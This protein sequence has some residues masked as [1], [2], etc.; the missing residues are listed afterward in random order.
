MWRYFVVFLACLELKVSAEGR[1]SFH[2]QLLLKPLPSGKVLAH[3]Q[4]VVQSNADFRQEEDFVHFHLFPRSLGQLISTYGVQELHVSLTQ[5]LWR[6]E[7][8]GYPVRSAPPGAEAYAWFATNSSLDER[9]RDVTNGL[10]GL[11]CASLSSINSAGTAQPR[12]TLEPEGLDQG[13]PSSRLRYSSLPREIVCTENLTPFK[14]LLPCSD[15]SGIAQL[16]SAKSVMDGV[17]RSLALH[18]RP[19]CRVSSDIE[20]TSLGLELSLSLTQVV[21]L[22]SYHSTPNWSLKKLFR[23]QLPSACPLATVSRAMVDITQNQTLYEASVTPKP[24]ST[25]VLTLFGHQHTL[26]VYDAHKINSSRPVNI[27]WRYS[28]PETYAKVPKPVFFIERLATGYGDQDGG[29]L[30]R[31][32]NTH[33]DNTLSLTYMETTLWYF[34]LLLHTMQATV[35]GQPVDLWPNLTYVAAKDRKKPHQLEFDL[36]LPPSSV[37]EIRMEFDKAFQIWNEFPPDAHHGF[38]MSSGV[39]RVLNLK[40]INASG[41]LGLPQSFVMPWQSSHES[42]LVHSP[43][44]LIMLPTPDFSMPYNV[45]CLSCTVV[46]IAFGSMHNL[47]IKRFTL[48]A[49]ASTSLKD[50]ILKLFRRGTAQS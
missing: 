26:A 23:S 6:T 3:F 38:Y 35:N 1:D 41:L 33:P 12:R 16:L 27:I 15:K 49:A 4:F 17:Y 39:A 24:S 5:G 9:W 25:Q 36:Q 7:D 37:L 13:N 8:W 47:S 28:T 48:Q 46:A 30:V 45:I 21:D 31:L 10:S 40:S 44:L 11:L 2:E 20:C 43:P 32:H 18:V 50:R 34:R 14:K 42:L 19:I 29:L 22:L